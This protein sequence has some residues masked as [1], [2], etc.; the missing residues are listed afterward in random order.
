MQKSQ[1]IDVPHVVIVSS[2]FDSS[3]H[4]M[5]LGVLRKLG[6]PNMTE[7]I[8]LVNTDPAQAA[9]STGGVVGAIPT[10]ETEPYICVLC[11]SSKYK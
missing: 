2:H 3:A 7:I 4:I 8:L 5:L 9:K 1:C 11:Q 10:K 6:L